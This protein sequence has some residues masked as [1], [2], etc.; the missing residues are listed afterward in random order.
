MPPGRALPGGGEAPGAAWT[1]NVTRVRQAAAAAAY[2][3]TAGPARVGHGPQGPRIILLP[4]VEG[5]G[6][7][8]NTAQLASASGAF[9]MGGAATRA[10]ATRW[11]PSATSA[12]PHYSMSASGEPGQ[13]AA[14]RPV[15]VD[16]TTL[17]AVARL[18]RA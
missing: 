9:R 17:T 2:A 10:C 16:L 12:P 15:G 3:L 7:G 6:W 14:S 13:H 18:N 5:G 1:P 11:P 8:G 4:H